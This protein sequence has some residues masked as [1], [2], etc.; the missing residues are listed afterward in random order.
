MHTYE[1]TR[2]RSAEVLRMT[3][4]LMGQYEAAFNPLTFAV[5]YEHAAGINGR[6]SR[7]V[8]AARLTDPRIGDETIARLYQ[9]Y[10]CPIDAQGMQRASGELERV[11]SGLADSAASTSDRAGSFGETLANFEDAL[12][13][14]R[15]SSELG[16]ALDK[17]RGSTTEMKDSTAALAHQV[18]MGRQEIQ[19]LR[20][21]LSRAR[22]DAMIDPLTGVLN[23][24]GFDQQIEAMLE[25]ARE[26]GQPLSVV[27]FDIDRFKAVNDTYGHV[28][29]D[30]VLQAVAEV[31]RSGMSNSSNAL[32][33]YGGE[34]FAA[35]LP[36]TH[37]E[38]AVALAESCRLQGKA[39]RVLDRR[40][41]EVM[42]TVTI[43]AGT[44]A[45]RPNDDSASLIARADQALYS[46]KQS[47]RDRV[48]CA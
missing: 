16:Q 39:L 25:R 32:A 34:E 6:L 14:A 43:S 38:D 41:Q 30:R 46:A 27:M 23:R 44:S 31:L 8:E 45:S 9:D 13:S 17:V 24:R 37:Q 7:A 47:G 5:W 10:V 3:L 42:L 20:E 18:A 35:L 28:M 33:R 40:K 15:A 4:A 36:N 1:E 22:N 29:G 48:V 21:D 26:T 2:E 19:R 11:M 12:T